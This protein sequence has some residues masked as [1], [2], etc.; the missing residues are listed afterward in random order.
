M[1]K[2]YWKKISYLKGEHA[3]TDQLLSDFRNKKPTSHDAFPPKSTK[4]SNENIDFAIGTPSQCLTIQLNSTN[5][6]EG[7]G[8]FKTNLDKLLKEIRKCHHQKYLNTKV[9]I[10]NI[11]GKSSCLEDYVLTGSINRKFIVKIWLFSSA[12]SVDVEGYTKFTK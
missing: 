3:N 12:K 1:N 10:N 4:E 2:R 7:D 5:C 9:I 6:D 11:I 8:L